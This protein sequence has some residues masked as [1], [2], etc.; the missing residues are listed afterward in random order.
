MR[1][2][3]SAA[4]RLLSAILP[5]AEAGACVPE[6][7]DGWLTRCRCQNNR[8]FV[9]RCTVQCLGNVTCGTCYASDIHC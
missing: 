6:H 2:I 1:M 4:D 8:I 9:K 5:K 7:G 3:N